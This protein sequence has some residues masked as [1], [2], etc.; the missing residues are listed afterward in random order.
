MKFIDRNNEMLLFKVLNPFPLMSFIGWYYL[1]ASK[2]QMKK[3][4]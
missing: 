1:S 4:G 3:S 2:Q